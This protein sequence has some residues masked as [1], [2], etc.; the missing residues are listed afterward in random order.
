MFCTVLRSQKNLSILFLDSQRNNL[1]D[2]LWKTWVCSKLHAHRWWRTAE[3][4][5]HTGC[6]RWSWPTSPTQPA[7][8]QTG[9]SPPVLLFHH[10][11]AFPNTKFHGAQKTEKKQGMQ[12]RGTGAVWDQYVA[13]LNEE[14]ARF[15]RSPSALLMAFILLPRDGRGSWS[16]GRAHAPI[17]HTW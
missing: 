6:H 9:D 15:P 5:R 4:Y 11:P 14:L 2:W 10:H 7:D 1:E 17:Y 16:M 13:F 12:G 3:V 8:R